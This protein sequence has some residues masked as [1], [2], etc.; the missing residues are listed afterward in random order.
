MLTFAFHTFAGAALRGCIYNFG[1]V[2][3]YRRSSHPRGILRR[4]VKWL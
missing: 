1:C 4:L 2:V 3:S